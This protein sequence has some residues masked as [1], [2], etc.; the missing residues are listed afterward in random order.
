[1]CPSG[2]HGQ[3]DARR[4]K[5]FHSYRFRRYLIRI[6]KKHILDRRRWV[7]TAPAYLDPPVLGE[8]PQTAEI[9]VTFY[10]SYERDFS[11]RDRLRVTVAHGVNRFLVPNYL[12][13]QTVGQRQ[14]CGKC[15]DQRTNLL[16]AHVFFGPFPGPFRQC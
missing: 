11:D 13:Q 15:R 3:L 1:M 2:L 16:S 10:G 7:S 5:F 14:D 8:F 6:L 12:V 9:P 4:R